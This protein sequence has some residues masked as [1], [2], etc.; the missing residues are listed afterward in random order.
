MLRDP[1]KIKLKASLWSLFL[2]ILI[3]ICFLGESFISYEKKKQEGLETAKQ[4]LQE[5]VKEFEKLIDSDLDRTRNFKE[6]VPNKKDLAKL[7]DNSEFNFFTKSNS[8]TYSL[9]TVLL[10]GDKDHIYS[11]YGRVES[12]FIPLEIIE[13]CYFEIEKFKVFYKTDK[14]Y[15][16]KGYFYENNVPCILF[17][18]QDIKEFIK[19][20]N[21]EY[22]T[23][24]LNSGSDSFATSSEEL[25]K[26]LTLEYTSS[27]SHFFFYTRGVLLLCCLLFVG[28]GHGAFMLN[29]IKLAR[30]IGEKHVNQYEDISRKLMES[31][32]KIE[33]FQQE[34]SLLKKRW[35]AHKVSQE[36]KDRIFK[37]IFPFSKEV[38]HNFQELQ[39]MFIT[40]DSLQK[41]ENVI[42]KFSKNLKIIENQ[43][44]IV[45]LSLS[46]TIQEIILS[47]SDELTQ[48]N[49]KISIKGRDFL[50]SGP[51][52][53]LYYVIYFVLKNC[54]MR[55]PPE[56]V[57][58][59]KLETR[60]NF[61]KLIIED[62]GFILSDDRLKRFES[63][64]YDYFIEP[65]SEDLLKAAFLLGW[66]IKQGDKKGLFN[67]TEIV[68]Q[69]SLSAEPKSYPGANIINLFKLR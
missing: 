35:A 58:T 53:T 42:E 25:L 38:L 14:L 65:E 28:I 50:I 2:G 27:W 3:I 40:H 19:Y 44:K 37:K 56:G 6:V 26:H 45:K 20:A 39:Q 22:I 66:T 46:K 21:L 11:K 47:F 60:S 17:I 5:R 9:Y 64:I 1:L 10:L 33:K 29:V 41:S 16:A 43:S 54:V 68:M 62:N 59:I 63:S 55:V 69:C 48:N 34:N 24:K 30:L 57:M 61:S 36:A 49:I 13:R 15:F 7:Y 51:L 4:A 23:L 12:H 18:S 52:S 8:N 67:I 31:G 32:G